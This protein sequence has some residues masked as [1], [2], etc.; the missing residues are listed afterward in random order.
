M[1]G[2]PLCERNQR[3]AAE[4]AT[5]LPSIFANIVERNQQMSVYR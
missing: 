1:P 4:R 5:C 3:R 2:E